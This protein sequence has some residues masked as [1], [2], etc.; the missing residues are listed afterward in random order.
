MESQVAEETVDGAH[1]TEGAALDGVDPET[2]QRFASAFLSTI[3]TAERA[4]DI[5]ARLVGPVVR[6]G[7]EPVG[8]GDLATATGEGRPGPIRGHRVDARTLMV[9]VPVELDVEVAVGGRS[10]HQDIE[11]DVGV[12]VHPRLTAEPAVVADVEQ[13]ARDDIEVRGSGV[14]GVLLRGLGL[15]NDV[16]ALVVDHVRDMLATPP[17]RSACRIDLAELADRA[18]DSALVLPPVADPTDNLDESS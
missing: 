2:A 12:R 16:R 3:V 13:V 9:T 17:A 14:T 4:A 10:V 1:S 18:W 7:P 11:I 8:P 6:F 5:V 15:E